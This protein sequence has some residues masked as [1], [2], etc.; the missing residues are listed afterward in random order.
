MNKTKQLNQRQIKMFAMGT[1][2]LNHFAYALLDPTSFLFKIFIYVGYFTA[3]TMC[4]FLVE[5]Y[6]YTHSKKKYGQ[7]LL[8]FAVISQIPFNMVSTTKGIIH[9]TGFNMIFTLFICFLVLLAKDKI[10]NPPLRQGVILLL[11]LFSAYSDWG[12]LA[13]IFTIMFANHYGSEKG[14]NRAF[15]IAILLQGFSH[16]IDHYMFTNDLLGSFIPALWAVAGL[17]LSKYVIMKLYNGSR[18]EI[19]GKIQ[20]W[21]FYLFYPAHLFLIGGIRIL[22]EV[23]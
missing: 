9:F 16:Y 1:M 19:K 15:N 21:F 10:E 20:Q 8:V 5:G 22:L 2:F 11:V 18:G 23:L 17:V 13:P 4:Y 7:R 6:V 14:T 12:I 3:I